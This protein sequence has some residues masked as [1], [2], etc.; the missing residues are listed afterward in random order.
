MAPHARDST[1][2]ST[3]SI[4]AAD[5]ATGEVGVAVQSKYL[6]VG[7]VVPWARAGVGA[8]ATQALGL[9]RYGPDL[10]ARLETGAHPRDALPSAL[11]DDPLASQRQIGVVR[12]DGQA[13]THTGDACLEWAGG[14]T[15]SGYA[16]QGNILAGPEVV[17][18]MVR[19]FTV[20]P[21]TLAERLVLA[22]EAGQAAGGDRRGQQSA[23]VLVE[24]A[25]YR[26]LGSEGI[27]KIFDIRVDD[28]PQPI[29]ELRRVLGLRLRQEVSGRAMRLYNLRDFVRAAEMMGEGA[30]RYPGSPDMLYNL[31]CFESLAGRAGDSLTH[32]RQA[33]ALDASYREL[34]ARDTDFDPLRASTEFLAVLSP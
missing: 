31:A 27:D 16:A 17:D 12:A 29:V 26:D 14:R 30:A 7:A 13:S 9:A 8:V 32:L 28:H 20:A 22:L 21:G 4:V 6:A 2:A 23:A 1:V 33:V 10:L 3:F 15:G 11:A 25:G 34:A 24:Q 18:E 5:P 19:A